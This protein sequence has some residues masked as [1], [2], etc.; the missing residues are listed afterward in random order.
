MSCSVAKDYPLLIRK[1]ADLLCL[2]SKA[3]PS[4]A[5]N[6][7][8]NAPN[9]FLKA[10]SLIAFNILNG[11]FEL[12]PQH[13]DKLSPYADHIR[14]LSKKTLSAKK[15]RATLLKGGFLPAILGYYSISF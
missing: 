9:D 11:Y 15:R 12:E 13:M 7:I 2:L 6:L 14:V 10:L 5:R 1:N 4:S 3:K 8:K